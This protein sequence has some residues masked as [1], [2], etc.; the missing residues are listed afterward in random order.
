ML[1]TKINEIIFP[2][3][4][5]NIQYKQLKWIPQLPSTVQ[6]TQLNLGTTI[7]WSE[8]IIRTTDQW[9]DTKGTQITHAGWDFPHAQK[10]KLNKRKW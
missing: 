8:N 9:K 4:W 3:L 10:S 5:D 2:Y 1:V 6:N 7:S